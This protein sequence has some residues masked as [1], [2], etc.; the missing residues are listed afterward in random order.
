MAQHKRQTSHLDHFVLLDA[1]RCMHRTQDLART[2]LSPLSPPAGIEGPG[3]GKR[4][5]GDDVISEPPVT[6]HLP[7]LTSTRP[8]L[9]FAC[10]GAEDKPNPG[11]NQ[12]LDDFIPLSPRA[13]TKLPASQPAM[14]EEISGAAFLEVCEYGS[15]YET[16]LPNFPSA[17][18]LLIG[19]V[20]PVSAIEIADRSSV[21][22]RAA[23]AL[24]RLSTSDIAYA[25][26]DKLFCPFSP[27][28]LRACMH[29]PTLGRKE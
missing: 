16:R 17:A 25:A 28:R 7:S 22:A 3:R 23:Y 9:T 11:Q 8:Q 6:Q 20:M 15:K 27:V 29:S 19:L 18:P 5:L 21:K 24:V 1:D 13:K 14:A 12:G 10:F 2:C 4:S 26:S